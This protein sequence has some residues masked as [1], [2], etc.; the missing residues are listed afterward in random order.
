LR[1]LPRAYQI[2][3]LSDNS[4]MFHLLF[5]P[6]IQGTTV[7]V[8][9][10]D[11]AIAA[12]LSCAHVISHA[13]PHTYGQPLAHFLRKIAVVVSYSTLL[14]SYLNT[15]WSGTSSVF[16]YMKNLLPRKN[17]LSQRSN[18]FCSN[19]RVDIVFY[20]R[21]SPGGHNVLGTL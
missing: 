21:Q 12:D 15:R 16:L 19:C 8:E 20:G 3:I 17:H 6:L 2:K 13:F 18:P 14:R 4:I 11:A 1:K 9:Y 7:R 10:G 5:Y